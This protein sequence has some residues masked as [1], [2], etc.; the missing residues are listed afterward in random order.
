M[1]IYRFEEIRVRSPYH[2]QRV[3]RGIAL[4]H[5]PASSKWRTLGQTFRS[6]PDEVL[7][8]LEAGRFSMPADAKQGR[9][10]TCG[11]T[12]YWLKTDNGKWQLTDPDGL[13]HW[14]RCP[15]ERRVDG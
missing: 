1:Q 11:A 15:N 13:P 14:P 5:W 6:T 12:G 8:A 9:C 2:W 3:H 4:D 10:K 7:K